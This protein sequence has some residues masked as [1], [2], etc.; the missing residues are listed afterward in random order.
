MWKL[1]TPKG[2]LSGTLMCLAV[3]GARAQDPPIKATLGQPAAR[4]KSDKPCGED[5]D[6]IQICKGDLK[7]LQPDGLERFGRGFQYTFQRSEQPRSVVVGS[8]ST[9]EIIQNPEHYLNQHSLTFQFSELF[10][11]SSDFATMV[12]RVY[13]DKLAAAEDKEEFAKKKVLLKMGC[14]EYIMTCLAAGSSTWKRALS[15]VKVTGSLSE[16]QGVQLGV[17]VPEGAFSNHYQRTGE[18]DFDP[19]QIFITGTNWKTAMDALTK[20]IPIDPDKLS[21]S[22]CFRPAGGNV[23]TDKRKSC[24][25]DFALGSRI[26][27]SKSRPYLDRTLAA[28][29]PTFQF[30]RIS[31]FDFV[32]SSGVLIPG[33]YPETA[34]N[35]Y[36]A[37]WDLR[38]LIAVTKARTDADAAI[39]GYENPLSLNGVNKPSN[40]NKQ[41]QIGGDPKLCITYSGTAGSSV[42]VPSTFS[43]DS[44]YRFAKKISASRYALAC[45][46]SNDVLIGTSIDG[47]TAPNDKAKPDPNPC[48]W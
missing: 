31:V 2:V 44:C 25:A 7:L 22:N 34:L 19:T 8:G 39:Y 11:S 38:R 6:T 35:N 13:K 42:S 3:I 33:P 47:A 40:T 1:C 46:S 12:T 32:K 37:T 10:P 17:L 41:P 21:E 4:D 24:L 5:K 16:L 48:G 20:I 15:G 27:G 30:K 43:A 26:T 18:I 29:I 36:T 45:V 23:D 14:G 28:L 9:T